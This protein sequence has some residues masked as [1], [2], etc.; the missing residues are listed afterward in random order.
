MNPI[1]GWALAA[2]AVAAAWQAYRWP[3]VAL[4]ATVIVFWLLLQFSRAVRVM[5]NA[6][7]APVGHVG[8]AVMLNAKLRRGMTMMQVVSSTRSLGRKHPSEPDSWI[9][10]DDSG[11]SVTLTLR[12]GKLLRWTL[13]RHDAAP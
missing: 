11:A 8:S 1:L 9:W 4:A 12:A 3:G 10:A 5:K 2:A 7:D 6:A 13:D